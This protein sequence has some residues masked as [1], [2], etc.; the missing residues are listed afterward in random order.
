MFIQLWDFS[1][2]LTVYYK[3]MKNILCFGDGNT[4][5]FNPE[6][7]GRYG[8][9]E[10]WTGILQDLLKE[11]YNI[12]EEGRNART[13]IFKDFT[14]IKTCGVDYLPYCLNI[15]PN[16]DMIIIMLGINDF[17]TLFRASVDDVLD[18]IRTIVDLIRVS[19]YH[20]NTKILFLAPPNISEDVK[21]CKFGCMF[22]EKSVQKSKHYAEKL[23]ILAE[24][25]NCS[26]FNLNDIIKTCSE[27][28]IHINSFEH[29]KVANTV[30]DLVLQLL[31]VM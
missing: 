8:K 24:K 4:Y 19:E 1:N 26:F 18:G 31:P 23:K 28:G 14:D 17:Q 27:D 16:I 22:D 7:G 13:V 15:Y 9:N 30:A 29:K 5:G 11:H 6:T 2:Y 10:R 12:I 3:H 20:K 21:G 25:L